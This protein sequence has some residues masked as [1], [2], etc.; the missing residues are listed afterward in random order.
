M[1]DSIVIIGILIS[2]ILS[3]RFAI[4]W[5]HT[6]GK[7]LDTPSNRKRHL[8]A[9]PLVGGVAFV[10]LL[11]FLSMSFGDALHSWGLVLGALGFLALGLWDDLADLSASMR[12]WI[13]I[14]TVTTLVI[15]T[16]T[17]ISSLLK[18]WIDLGLGPFI[19]IFTVFTIVFFVNSFN[20]LDGIDGLASSI[21]AA[22]FTTFL[23]L[24]MLSGLSDFSQL[25]RYI[26]AAVLSF[27]WFN[28]RRP[29][30]PSARTFLG[31]SGSMT[32]GFLIAWCAIEFNN[33]ETLRSLYPV[34]V[35]LILSYPAGDALGVFIRRARNGQ[36]P[37]LPDRSHL[38]HL[39]LRAGF[40]VSFTQIILMLV[41]IGIGVLT[42]MLVLLGASEQAQLVTLIVILL[43]FIGLILYGSATIRSIKHIRKQFR[44]SRN[45]AT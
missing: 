16:D 4:W 34:T 5:S 42:V 6:T 43:S 30:L 33:R 9:T 19:E 8:E 11:F 22:I 17:Q 40:S 21:A 2:T 39:F 25:V 32:L 20:M 23:V 15:S 24:G 3:I 18:V 27:V 12:F 36:N 29:G 45:N 7:L 44:V 14:V 38:H 31:D 37:M 1:A 10:P 28:M 13:Q 41:Q 35:A 26:L